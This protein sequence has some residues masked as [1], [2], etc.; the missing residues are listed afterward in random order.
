MHGG[1][2]SV[3][4]ELPTANAVGRRRTARYTCSMSPATKEIVEAALKLDPKQRQEIA[5]ELWASLEAHGPELGAAWEAELEKR[6][7]EIESGTV[8]LEPWSEVRENLF[9]LARE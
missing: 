2:H 4:R 7:A 9:R 5:E 1:M 3:T 8:K 6:A